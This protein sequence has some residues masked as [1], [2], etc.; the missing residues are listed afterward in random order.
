MRGYRPRVSNEAMVI[1][2]DQPMIAVFGVA[3]DRMDTGDRIEQHEKVISKCL[4]GS[5]PRR[6]PFVGTIRPDKTMVSLAQ[7]M[8]PF[9]SLLDGAFLGQSGQFAPA[10]IIRHVEQFRAQS[11]WAKEAIA[12]ASAAEPSRET[13]DRLSE[14][15]ASINARMGLF[16]TDER[17]QVSDYGLDPR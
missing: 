13:F 8:A 2:R 15:R 14:Q 1:F 7:Q 17:K 11:A 12:A 5:R 6:V 10:T 16:S 4:E 9:R 3:Y